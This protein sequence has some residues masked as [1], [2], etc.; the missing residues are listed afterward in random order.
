MAIDGMS[1][2]TKG[3]VVV[4]IDI[5]WNCSMTSRRVEV[6]PKENPCMA[7]MQITSAMQRYEDDRRGNIIEVGMIMV[8]IDIGH[9]HELWLWWSSS[10]V[11][12]IGMDGGVSRQ[13]FPRD[14]RAK[15]NIPPQSMLS[16]EI[17]PRGLPAKYPLPSLPKT[18]AAGITDAH[19]PNKLKHL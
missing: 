4:R 5:F 10:V 12:S 14:F 15:T 3:V 6:T 18:P 17:P 1:I 7:V 2:V 16:R 13:K 11:A 9:E 8:D 19:A